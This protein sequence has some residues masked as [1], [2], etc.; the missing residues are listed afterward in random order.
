[1]N[2]SQHPFLEL[3]DAYALGTLG[4]E[5]R[6][7]LEAHLAAGCDECEAELRAI[8][9][10]A[11]M[12]AA[13]VTAEA[14][15][16]LLRERILAAVDASPPVD[17]ARARPV[18]KPLRWV[19]VAVAAGF[20]G[21][22]AG[23]WQGQFGLRRAED[24][25]RAREAVLV[26]DL[27]EREALLA[28]LLDPTAA[29]VPF[30]ATANT[31]AGL[32][33]RAVIDAPR[34]SAVITLSV[35]SLGDDQDYELWA[36]RDG[37]PVSLGVMPRSGAD[38]AHVLLQNLSDGGEPSALAVSLEAVGGSMTGVPATVVLLAQL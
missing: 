19:L 32:E 12:L 18:R 34:N 5:D 21:F 33:G 26:A 15:P 13:A 2:P 20:V 36:I 9:D 22:V 35:G 25:W 23:L 38:T 6:A 37:A 1:M 29:C 7:R 30:A 17:A 4:P 24:A 8:A 10:S 27:D 16:E 28:V 11:W 3:L 14:V 31:P